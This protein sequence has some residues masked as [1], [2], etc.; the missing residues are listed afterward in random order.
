M[1]SK[2]GTILLLMNNGE[3]HQIRKRSNTPAVLKKW[4]ESV[5]IQ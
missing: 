3:N 1:T 4:M 2:N 5:Y